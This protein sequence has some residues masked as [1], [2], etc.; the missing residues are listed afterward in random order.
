MAIIDCKKKFIAAA[1]FYA[2]KLG[3]PSNVV[4]VI[5]TKK[6]LKGQLGYCER[7]PMTK[8]ITFPAFLIMLENNRKEEYDNPLVVLAHEMVHVKQYVKGELEDFHG[9]SMWK[10]QRF[11]DF[12]LGSE[13]Y[14]FAPWEV[15]AYGYQ[16]GLY[17][18]Y[19]RKQNVIH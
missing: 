13:D 12:A 9:Y 19:L 8:D 10:G 18:T 2:E 17:E 1:Q 16:V 5:K 6:N 4:I 7:I 15:E 14:Y 11:E 3:I